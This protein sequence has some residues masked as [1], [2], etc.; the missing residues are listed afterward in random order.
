MR[1]VGTKVCFIEVINED[2]AFLMQQYQLV[3]ETSPDYQGMDPAVAVRF[4]YML[5]LYSLMLMEIS[6][7]I[8]L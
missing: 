1:S 3:A 7:I 4:R 8:I 5:E 6:M 2:P